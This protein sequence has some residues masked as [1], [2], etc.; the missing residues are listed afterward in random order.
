[1]RLAVICLSVLCA[2]TVSAP[3]TPTLVIA[4]RAASEDDASAG[5]LRLP[6]TAGKPAT[7]VVVES[8]CRVSAQPNADA[9]QGDADQFWRIHAELTKDAKGRVSARVRYRL[10][11]ASGAGAEQDKVIVLDGRDTLAIDA[12]SARTD[13]RYDRILVTISGA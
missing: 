11:K 4:Y 12:F 5:R 6:L 10:V 3:Q 8:E 7:A 1:M 13:C 9:P 2:V